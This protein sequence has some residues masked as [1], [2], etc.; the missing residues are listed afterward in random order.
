LKSLNLLVLISLIS[1]L[2]IILISGSP[3]KSYIN[4]FDHNN[5]I[6]LEIP[7]IQAQDDREGSEDDGG[8]DD[9]AGFEEEDDLDNEKENDD[10]EQNSGQ[11]SFE[12]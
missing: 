4:S 12:T 8:E 6:L 2:S 10:A 9:F 5:P 1:F 11:F 7:S 3:F